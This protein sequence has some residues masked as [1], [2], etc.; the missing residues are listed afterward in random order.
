MESKIF[1]PG[2]SPE[3]RKAA[4]QIEA[5]KIRVEDYD[6]PM[7]KDTIENKKSDFIELVR[8]VM[9]IKEEKKEVM[10]N[11]TDKIKDLETT[12]E[13]I[14]WELKTGKI[15]ASGTLYDFIDQEAGEM[16]TYNEHGEMVSQRRLTIEEKRGQSTIFVMSK[17]V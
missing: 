17:A 6:L 8:K 4:M 2:C 5:A 11:F 7:D 13:T 10:K 16:H 15:K 1:M 3:D 14:N 9:D 12:I